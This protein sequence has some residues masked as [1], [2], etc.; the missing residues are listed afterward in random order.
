MTD[1]LAAET[2]ELVRDTAVAARR[3]ARLRDWLT[4]D[5]QLYLAETFRD[6]GDELDHGR[7]DRVRCAVAQRLRLITLRDPNGRPLYRLL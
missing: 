4:E 5:Q 7:G 1:N 3:V 6:C 2:A